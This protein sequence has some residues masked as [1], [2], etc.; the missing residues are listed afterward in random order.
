VPQ[1]PFGAR[2]SSPDDQVD[3]ECKAGRCVQGTCCA[4]NE[5]CV[6]VCFECNNQGRCQAHK[7]R[8]TVV[9]GCPQGACDGLGSCRGNA[10][11]SCQAPGQAPDPNFCFSQVCIDGICQ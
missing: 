8:G 1:K 6:G 10:G 11:A 2:C 5:F 3:Q 7:A 9:D 4:A